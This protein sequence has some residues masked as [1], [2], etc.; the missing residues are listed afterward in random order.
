MTIGNLVL[1]NVYLIWT[2]FMWFNVTKYKWGKDDNL[3]IFY[4]LLWILWGISSLL[5]IGFSIYA[6]INS[7]IW[8]YKLF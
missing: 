1:L 8:N 4:C 6:I 5:L 7:E 3:D 2:F